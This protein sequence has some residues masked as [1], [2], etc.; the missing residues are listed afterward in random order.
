MFQDQPHSIDGA[1]NPV[2]GHIP[3]SGKL[4]PLLEKQPS[5]NA[6]DSCFLEC[7]F[8]CSR[9]FQHRIC[10]RTKIDRNVWQIINKTELRSAS[11]SPGQSTAKRALFKTL[12]S[13]F[14]AFILF[15][16]APNNTTKYPSFHPRLAQHERAPGTNFLPV[17]LGIIMS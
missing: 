14:S 6:F 4:I 13:G 12:N 5:S 11:S 8:R 9:C 3:C 1:F 7:P 10:G 15:L 2:L 17:K 16:V